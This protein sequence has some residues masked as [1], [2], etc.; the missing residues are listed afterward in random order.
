MPA[1]CVRAKNQ[2]PI[3]IY[4]DHSLNQKQT[5]N[6]DTKEYR[7]DNG[8]LFCAISELVNGVKIVP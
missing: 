5:V 6:V 2:L 8:A 3:N 7:A 1:A 4:T